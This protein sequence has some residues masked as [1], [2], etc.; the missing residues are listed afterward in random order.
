MAI[1][2]AGDLF[3]N[4]SFET[5]SGAALT[6]EQVVREQKYTVFWAM[7]FIGCR[8]CQCDLDALSDVYGRF[9]EK[10]AQVYAILQ[11]SRS[12]IKG[13]K[14]DDFTVPYEIICD[15][16]HKFYQELSVRATATKEERMPKTPEG[17]AKLEEKRETVAARGYAHQSGEGEEQQLPALFIVGKDRRIAYAH[18][19][20][21]SVDMPELD[22]ILEIL[23]ELEG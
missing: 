5:Y 4:I 14:G 20:E 12:S 11:S 3:P 7:R 8:F 1:V 15:T 17:L 6:V 22:R 16:E 13:L 23:A 10:G 2:K 18:Y 9:T 19:A 21:N